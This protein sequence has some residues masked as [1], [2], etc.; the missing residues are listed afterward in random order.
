MSIAYI[1]KITAHRLMF[2]ETQLP[3]MAE[4]GQLA[5]YKNNDGRAFSKTKAA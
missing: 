2:L 5:D 4:I 1:K 3:F